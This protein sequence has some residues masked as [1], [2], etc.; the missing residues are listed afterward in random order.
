MAKDQDTRRPTKPTITIEEVDRVLE[1]G[2][3]LL[4]VL[5]PEELEELAGLMN[6]YNPRPLTR[7]DTWLSVDE[8]HSRDRSDC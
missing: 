4:S 5:T 3:L 8:T 7:A 1:V 6:G 2:R